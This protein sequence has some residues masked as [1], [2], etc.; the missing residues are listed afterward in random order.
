MKTIPLQWF[1][2]PQVLIG[3]G[4]ELLAKFFDHFRHDLEDLQIYLP[5]PA[6]QTG[7]YFEQLAGV[8]R[9]PETWPDSFEQALLAVEHMASPAMEPRRKALLAQIPPE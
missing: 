9:S 1:T 4:R 8:L 7:Y 3:L 2:Q 6:S 5:N